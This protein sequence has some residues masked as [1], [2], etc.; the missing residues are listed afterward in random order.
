MTRRCARVAEI[1]AQ[2][3]AFDAALRAARIVFDDAAA[4]W[5]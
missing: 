2:S 5:E 4:E 1:T 3:R